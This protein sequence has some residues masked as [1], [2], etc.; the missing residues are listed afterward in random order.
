MR[1]PRRLLRAFRLPSG[2]PSDG[3]TD[4]Q[5]E[6]QVEPLARVGDDQ[7]Q[8]RLYE[9]GVVQEKGPE[10]AHDGGKRPVT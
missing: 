3:D 2:Q 6:E 10:R 1:A 8:P 4:E 5:K 7:G 9:E